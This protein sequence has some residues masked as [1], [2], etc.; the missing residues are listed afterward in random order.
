MIELINR[1][2]GTDEPFI[3][4]NQEPILYQIDY[5][6]I[7]QCFEKQNEIEKIFDDMFSNAKKDKWTQKHTQDKTGKSELHWIVY[8]FNTGDKVELICFDMSKKLEA[9]G[10]YDRFSVSL[11]LNEFKKFLLDVHYK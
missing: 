4:P 3:T 1:L 11:T 10:K 6:E 9:E 7:K 2:F 5:K 8:S